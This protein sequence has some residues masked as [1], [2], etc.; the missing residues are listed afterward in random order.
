MKKNLILKVLSIFL[1]AVLLY[2]TVIGNFSPSNETTDILDH[3]QNESETTVSIILS[4]S[5]HKQNKVKEISLEEAHTIK[6]DLLTIE[7]EYTSEEKIRKQMEV[8]HRNGLLPQSIDLNDYLNTLDKLENIF[9][10][11]QNIPTQILDTGYI[12]SGPSI[13][14]TFSIGGQTFRLQSFVGD[15]LEYYFDIQLLDYQDNDTL[16]GTHF[17]SSAYSGPVFVGISPASAF[18][19]TL[20]AVITGPSFIYAP[21]LSIRVLFSG[22]H[23]TAKIF[24]CQNPITVFD[25][26]LNLAALGVLIYQ[27][28]S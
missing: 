26:H 1:I 6:N 27:S 14:S 4:D 9:G 12:F 18:I 16:N 15:I 5:E 20:G 17:I 21:F 13:E 22:I 25:W 10:I 3:N 8:L 28:N 2:P 11:Q 24:E 7:N 23:L 19:T